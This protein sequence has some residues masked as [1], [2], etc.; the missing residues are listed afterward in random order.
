MGGRANLHA[1]NRSQTRLCENACMKYTFFLIGVLSAFYGKAQAKTDNPLKTRTDSSVDR[2]ALTYMSD[3][4]RVGLSAG[5]VYGGHSYTYNYG[6]TGPSTG[7]L[8]SSHTLYEIGSVTKTFT[9]LLLAHAKVQKRIDW[10][11][12]IRRYL[13]GAY[14]ALQYTNGEAVKLVYLLAHISRF[15]RAFSGSADNHF[16]SDDLDRELQQMRLDTLRPYKYRYSNLGYQVLGRILENIYGKKYDD[17]LRQEITGPLKMRSTKVN[18][19]DS[20]PGAGGIRSTINDMNLYMEYQLKEGDA[21]VK[22]THHP[23]FGDLLT[24]GNALPWTVGRTRDWDY[25]IREDGGTKGYRCFMVLYPDYQ[26]GIMLMTN[27]TDDNAG[28]KLYEMATAIFKD[29]KA[30]ALY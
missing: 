6:R 17:L 20:F 4:S 16:T 2:A 27:Q 22:M 5:I 15:P 14:P 24:G 11:D 18:D 3:S 19:T 12:D 26:V 7:Q 1:T 23:L 13:K 9:A 25:F 29:L 8:P 21:L 28:R 10:N 30:G